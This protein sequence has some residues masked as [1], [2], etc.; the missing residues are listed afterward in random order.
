MA[1]GLH[2]FTSRSEEVCSSQPPA[3]AA[4]PLDVDDVAFVRTLCGSDN[5]LMQHPWRT[6]AGSFPSGHTVCWSL[7]CCACSILGP[8]LVRFFLGSQSCRCQ[9]RASQ[10]PPRLP[11]GLSPEDRAS[12]ATPPRREGSQV[13]PR[14]PEEL[15]PD[16]TVEPTHLSE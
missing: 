11:E 8:A 9:G 1:A 12:E 10:T 6:S 2:D 3:L 14:L 15:C 7:P 5:L 4:G 16:V 13:S